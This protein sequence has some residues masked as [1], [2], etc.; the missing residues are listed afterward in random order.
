MKLKAHW[1]KGK[2]TATVVIRVRRLDEDEI[3]KELPPKWQ[4]QATNI[5]IERKMG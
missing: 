1:D 5:R 2:T 3:W 4:R